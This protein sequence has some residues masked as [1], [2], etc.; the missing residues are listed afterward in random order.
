MKKPVAWM[1]S[2]HVA[3]NLLMVFV[4]LT[5]A[6][7]IAGMKIETFPEIELDTV[8]IQVP[9][10]GASPED[11]EEGVCRRIEERLEGME[12]VRKIRS[13]ASEGMGVVSVEL[14][15]GEEMD[16]LVDDIKNEIDRIETF[17]VETEKP[18]IKELV[19][20]NRVVDVIVFGD[21]SEAALKTAAEQVRD[22]LRGR[23]GISKVE[24]L[25]VRIDEIAIE[26]SE[27]ALR[28]HG[29]TISGVADAVRRT[30]L[31]LPG[32]SVR[33]DDG[34]VLVRTQGLKYDGSEYEDVV[35][36]TR[37][38]G[39][40]L[41]L[42]EIADIVDGFEDSDLISRF[43]GYPAAVIQV[44]RTGDQSSLE[45]SDTVKAYVEGEAR[46]FMPAGISIEYVRDD[47][48]ILR[49]R[50]DLLLRNARLG[51]VLVFIGLS[52]FLDIRL[53][54]WV[55][56]GIP[57]SFLGSF[58]LIQ[59]FDVS[60]NMLSLFAFIVALGIVV[61]DAI[62]VGE[63]VFAHRER[64]EGMVR[65]AVDGTL[66]VGKPVVFTILTSIAAFM[67]LAFVDGMMGKFMIVIPIIVVSVLILSLVEAL[68]IL[69]AHLSSPAGVTSG[70]LGRL[71]AWPLRMHKGIAAWANGLL[72]RFVDNH[73]TS[74]AQAT[75]RRPSMSVA[76]A[77]ALM[78]VTCGWIAGGHIKFVFMPSIDSDWLTVA[79]VM[80]QGTTVDQTRSVIERIE[81]AAI[82]VREEYDAQRGPDEPSV[83]R[84]VFSLIGDQPMGRNS[85]F[86]SSGG[87]AG[88][89]HLAE[90]T[91]ELLP[92]EERGIPSIEMAT[93]VRERLG[94][95]SGTESITFS[96]TIFS[97]AN[98]IEVQLA[99]DDFPQ[100]LQAVER[101]KTEISR[102]PG[103]TD[104]QDS[105]QEGK[106]E[107]KLQLKPQARTLGLTMADLARQVREGFYGAQALRLQ[108]GRD[109]VRVMVRYPEAQRQSIADIER[110]R[111][112]TPT[113]A[114]V[115]F[116]H[117]AEVSIG[118]GYASIARTDGQRVVSVKAD[119]DEKAG[120][121]DEIN[122]ALADEFLPQLLQ[123]YPGL[124]YS[125]EGEQRERADSFAS[126][127]KGFAVAM[128]A[129]FA[130]LAIPF[131][132]YLQPLVV[133]SAIP[134]GMIGAVWGHVL[135][136]LDLAM[137]S[138]FGVVALS[139]VVVNDSLI[140]LTF[141]NQ[142]RDDGLSVDEAL[143]EAG[144]QR[145]RPIFLTS[146]T[147]FFALL[148]M[149]LETSLQAQF[150]IPMAVSLGFGILFATAIILVGVPTAMKLLELAL[151]R[152]GIVRQPLVGYPDA[153]D[154]AGLQPGS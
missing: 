53:A 104:V 39:T 25:G 109:D 60:I 95:V 69:P 84:N 51:L 123:D 19:R 78:L 9:Y 37:P 77:S 154:T 6:L 22:D 146:M 13:T 145:F 107:M 45:I 52:L 86:R 2:N 3:A 27:K 111:V 147:T 30:S 128:L 150:L 23:D 66:E 21:V 11:V 57:I 44:F 132:S 152:L 116:S 126:L 5:G 48:R 153:E 87:A 85:S 114:E 10:L 113:G 47:A 83:Y 102:Y 76:V 139:G 68:F 43:N 136:G 97:V 148:P 143:V 117:V 67:P 140:L 26:V 71:F 32:G 56:M 16:K 1:A 134:F 135:M 100:L 28:R 81:T 96:A 4:L 142:L 59:P 110:M 41:R 121:A 82:E 99:S 15:L 103:T 127:G 108:R 151:E 46:D 74:L 14:E 70:I 138:M 35:V 33:G 118:Y 122:R 64:G 112:R 98:P 49:S 50:L 149:M 124:R 65:A 80:P 141:Y 119:V 91:I 58:L 133:M 63:N 42:G 12:G 7:G 130:L 106:L 72:K 24:L 17:P 129:I 131:R 40:A 79:V 94:E 8:Q 73:Y 34:E 20:T 88:Q 75:L 92:S 120:N 101:V 90:I 31:D 55:M 29:I 89:A 38:D 115:A 137:L 18:V 93:R 54:F 61:D 125:Y 105:F 62:V 144:R 36:F